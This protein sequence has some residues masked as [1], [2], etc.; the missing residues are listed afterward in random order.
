MTFPEISFVKP[1]SYLH[2]LF[3]SNLCRSISCTRFLSKVILKGLSFLPAVQSIP[4]NLASSSKLGI[5]YHQSRSS[6]LQER[7]RSAPPNKPQPTDRRKM[8]HSSRTHFKV[9]VSVLENHSALR[10]QASSFVISELTCRDLLSHLCHVRD[11]DR[12]LITRTL[13]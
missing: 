13:V 11:H 8:K 10:S 12:K 6:C 7:H 2:L 3:S 5:Q 9:C 4:C 1:Q